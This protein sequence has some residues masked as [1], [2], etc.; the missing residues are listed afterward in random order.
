MRTLRRRLVA[1]LLFACG[2]R[3]P[4]A[5]AGKEVNGQSPG[6]WHHF[7]HL[8]YADAADRGICCRR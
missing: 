8:R 2:G 3:G 1:S 6:G 5:G 4:V 7:H